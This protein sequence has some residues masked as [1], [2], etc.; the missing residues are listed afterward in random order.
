[1][2][3][4]P[5][6]QHDP[7]DGQ[8]AKSI[9]TS[10]MDGTI[11]SWLSGFGTQ[12][13][14]ALDASNDGGYLKIDP[15]TASSGDN[16][17]IESSFGVTPADYDVIA[18]RTEFAVTTANSGDVETTIEL[19]DAGSDNGLIYSALHTDDT[20]DDRLS[21]EVGGGRERNRTR[22]IDDTNPH[23]L[24]LVWDVAD[25]TAGLYLDG[26]Q[27]VIEM[28]ASGLPTGSA[29]Y[30]KGRCIYNGGSAAHM[31]FYDAELAYYTKSQ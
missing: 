28:D 4:D 25:E 15:G 13:P 10:F 20:I 8:R 1:M 3:V 14:T 11:P 21:V 18:L 24:I 23:E 16:S 17:R 30:L 19:M 2:H 31:R 6:N 26:M 7:L 5:A 22:F 29:Y 27:G 9:S 12:S